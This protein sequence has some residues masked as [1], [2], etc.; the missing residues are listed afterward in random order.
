VKRKFN[1]KVLKIVGIIL[2][3]VILIAAGGLIYIDRNVEKIA[4]DFLEKEFKKSELVEVYDISYSNVKISLMYGEIIIEDLI[5]SPRES[6]FTAPDTLRFKYPIVYKLEIP[7][8]SVSGLSENFSLNLERIVLDEI[9]FNSP[10]ITMIDHL[11][12]DEK[13][14]ATAQIESTKADSTQKKKG[15]GGFNLS[16]FSVKNGN[17]E[18]FSR[19]KNKTVIKAGK[20]NIE[21]LNLELSPGH[22]LHTLITETFESAYISLGEISYPLDNGFYTIEVDEIINNVNDKKIIVNGFKPPTSAEPVLVS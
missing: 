2:A 18:F 16:G 7:E 10:G 14:L 6:F 3:V 19:N 12:A 13:K 15:P 21:I 8:F 4:E 11:S 17:F 9:K 22:I 1:I 20:I 5:I